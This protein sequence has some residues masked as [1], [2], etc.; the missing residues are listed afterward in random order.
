[1]NTVTCVGLSAQLA[2]CAAAFAQQDHFTLSRQVIATG[3]TR[4]V[5]IAAPPG[6]TSRLF[7]LEQ[8]V[9][10][11]GR[12]RIVNLATNTVLPTPFVSVPGLA[13][14]NEQ[15][16]LG[17]CF[18][19]NYAQNGYLY[20]NY[21]R[22]TQ[23]VIERYTA[24][25]D[26]NLA[27]P[28][29]AHTIM[30][31]DRLALHHN[32]GWMEFGPDG[33]LWIGVG[34]GGQTMAPLNQP[35]AAFGKLL[36]ID[37]DGGDPFVVPTNNPWVG[38]AGLDTAWADGLRNPW[39]CAF[40]RVTGELWLADVGNAAQEEVNVVSSTTPGLKFGWP[41]WEGTAAYL[42]LGICPPQNQTVAPIHAYTHTGGNCSIT[43]GRVYRG[44]A[45]VALRGTYFF[46][47]ACSSKIWSLHRDATGSVR[48]V[49]RTSVV[50]GASFV[51]SFGEDAAGELYYCS[52]NGSLIRITPTD[53]SCTADLDGNGLVDATDLAQ[54]L[55]NWGAPGATRQD[56][57]ANSSVDGGDLSILLSTWGPC[58]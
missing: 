20:L 16:L 3:L 24:S 55:S 31:I 40:D 49:D 53:T 25:S 18:H 44:S 30:T 19:P 8:Y 5:G 11:T 38:V 9:S 4:P 50:Q 27:D 37:V 56:L 12:V 22:G 34:D 57:N 10:G 15:G 36:R 35:E 21:V 33:M 32:C 7:V 29:S 17:I 2:L 23:T 43:G 58:P 54:L 45:S 26:P 39:R 47:D 6:D 48:V 52:L 28:T 51:T 13:T 1:M 41:C 46:S 42:T 14:G